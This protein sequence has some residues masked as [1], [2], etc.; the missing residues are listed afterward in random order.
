[1]KSKKIIFLLIIFLFA[2]SCV[3]AAD[4]LTDNTLETD[5]NSAV[6]SDAP[7]IAQDAE[8]ASEINVTFDEK[9]YAENLTDITVNLPE[10]AQGNLEVRINNYSIYNETIT[11]KSVAIPIQLPPQKFP[12]FYVNLWPPYDSTH[13]KVTAFYNNVEINVTHDLIVMK[14]PQNHT[15]SVMIP[16]EVLQFSQSHY[17]I[18]AIMFPRSATGNVE[19]YLD[20]KLINKTNVT[21]PFVYFN[22]SIVTS[23]SL[24]I[25]N[26]SFVYSGDD[27]YN[28]CEGN[29][30]FN[31]TNVV[32]EIPKSIYLDHDDC[33]SV[34]SLAKG[35]VSVYIDSK[36]VKKQALDKYGEFIY[37]L[38]DDITC[39]NHEIK[40]VFNSKNFTRT[41]IANV[42]VTYDIDLTVQ[43]MYVYGEDNTIDVYIP[44]DMNVKLFKV[45]INNKTASIKK[46]GQDLWVDISKLP[47][48]NYTVNVT[49]LGD[50]K[51]YLMSVIDNFTV[52]Y[53][54]T[55]LNDI[56][57][58]DGSSIDLVLP[59]NAKGSLKVYLNDKL[60]K[61]VKLVKGKASIDMDNLNP[62]EYVLKVEY[63]G[64][65][66]D[67]SGYCTNLTVSPDLVYE[68]Y[69][70][71]G[72][73][74]M[75]YFEVPK[76]CKGKIS[77]KI[78][79]K[80]YSATIKNGIAKLDLSKLPVGDWDIDV[81][82]TGSD[83][84]KESYYVGVYVD[85]APIKIKPISTKVSYC[86]EYKVKVTGKTGKAIKNA[87]VTFKI[88]GKKVK[89]TK[90]NSK[91]IAK[92][93]LPSKYSPKKYTITAIYKNKKLS[94]KVSV[95]HVISLKTSK[96][97]KS[98]KLVLKASLKKSLKNK[99]VT[100]K[101]NGKTYKAKINSKGIAK[102]IVKKSALKN[103]KVGKKVTL[104]ATYLKDTV[105]KSVRV[106]K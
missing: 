56:T 10:T 45:T 23:A 22:E 43:R 5:S 94:K 70:L 19:I 80:V 21:A 60:F 4:N 38:F 101:F 76:S 15:P 73:K 67:V 6:Q 35:D 37:S 81:K 98:S 27:Y 64:S 103:L 33:I 1:M 62:G 102:V 89:S 42:N 100:F 39:G 58:N 26:M 17:Y 75:L 74:N 78:G 61:S 104:K 71:V 32:M 82:Y 96:I 34:R 16:E 97:K 77:A 84:F 95:K 66:Y 44:E 99:I 28:P 54:I 20:G 86:G 41:K 48:G 79:S 88:N 50:K 92:L 9:V 25:H 65:D 12:I 3:S 57:F 11:N 68:S 90:T 47:K 13:Y 2:M 53:E 106:K 29:I 105:K 85:Y 46:S 36:L 83:G 91:G 8:I 18:P 49:Y 69:V 14:Y 63:T 87:A 40:V 59:S 30:T 24:G 93:K 55:D 7:S 51:Y 31:V 72:E 52:D